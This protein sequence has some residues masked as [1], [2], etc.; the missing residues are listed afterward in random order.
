MIPTREEIGR[1]LSAAWR[2]FLN[3][4]RGM[5]GFDLSVNGFWRS[6]GAI[7]PMAPFYFVAFL[8][9]RQMR[10]ADPEQEAFSN[11][12]FFMA[13]TVAVAIDWV[14]FPIVLALFARQLGIGRSY[15]GFIIAR[16]WASLLI[17][18]PDSILAAIF[19][20]GILGQE[21]TGFISLAFLVIF[22]RFRFLIARIALG[23]SI[24]FALGVTLADFLFGL[25][26]TAGFNR[27]F[28]D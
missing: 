10:L 8:A 9:E 14:A 4:P 5:A 27:L 19:G 11:A 16:N 17:I 6:F 12:T 23:A 20:L 13:K 15:A 26:I 22:L 25:V 2:L 7:V 18:I 1:A 3:D 28:L 24:I 21:I